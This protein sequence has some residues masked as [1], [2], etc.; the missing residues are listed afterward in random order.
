[1]WHNRAQHFN[2]LPFTLLA[3]TEVVIAVASVAFDI[4]SHR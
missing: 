1:M 4:Y 3:F 2:G